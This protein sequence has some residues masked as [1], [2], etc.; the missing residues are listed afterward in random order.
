MIIISYLKRLSLSIESQTNDKTT[1][2]SKN[3]ILLFGES[4]KSTISLAYSLDQQR[5]VYVIT[6]AGGSHCL[7]PYFPNS[8][9]E[10]LN[11]LQHLESIIENLESEYTDIL[12]LRNVIVNNESE[13]MQAAE[14]YYRN[15]SYGKDESGNETTIDIWDKMYDAAISQSLPFSAVVLEEVNIITGWL[16]D[17]VAKELNLDSVV[18]DD[19]SKRGFDWNIYEKRVLNLFTRILKLPCLVILCTTDKLPTEQ[20]TGKQI[21]PDICSGKA[22]RKLQQMIGNI[23]YCYKE[24]KTGQ[25]RIQLVETKN[26]FAKDKI[27]PPFSDKRMDES[28][29]L[30]GRPQ[31]FWEYIKEKGIYD[32]KSS[33]N[34]KSKF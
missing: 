31:Y 11:N 33:N 28:I 17:E 2:N 27:I 20:Q 12:T 23:F 21:V 8:Y 10:S 3:K 14:S 30:T 1:L 22:N 32:N 5:P 6:P 34:G 7:S 24:D 29:D 9:V 13:R 26:V 15:F 4:G 19:K 25:H 16:Y 18:G